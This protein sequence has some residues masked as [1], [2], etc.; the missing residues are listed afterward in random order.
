MITSKNILNCLFLLGLF[1]FSFND[2]ELTEVFFHLELPYNPNITKEE[3]NV[4]LD[5]FH[6]EVIKILETTKP[7]NGQHSFV[8]IDK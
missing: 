3:S 2:I 4:Y 5:K 7:K 1:F 6:Q 8:L